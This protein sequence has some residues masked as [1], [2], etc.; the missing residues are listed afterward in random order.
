MEISVGQNIQLGAGV[1]LGHAYGKVNEDTPGYVIIG[2]DAHLRSNTVIYCDVWAGDGL[3]TGHNVVI[4]ENSFIGNN[5][6]IWSNSII[7]YSCSIGHDVRIHSCVYIAQYTV[8]KDDVFLAPGVVLAND[9]HPI[10]TKCMKGPIIEQGARIGINAT[11]LGRITI[12]EHSLVGAGSVVTKDVPPH[13][14]VQGNPAQVVCPVD[15]LECPL[16]L[17]DQPYKDGL[18]VRARE[19]ES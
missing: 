2:R 3:E 14:L 5:L 19:N 6:K 9:P 12:G 1:I 4:R 7:D 15:D 17:V 8:I 16:D 18:D 10:C 13:T 11:I